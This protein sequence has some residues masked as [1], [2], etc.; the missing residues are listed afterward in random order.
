LGTFGQFAFVPGQPSAGSTSPLWSGLLALGYLLRVDYRVWAYALGAA[1]LSLNAWLVYRL[2]LNLW[3]ERARAALLAGAFAALEW[4]MAWAAA[5]G[6]ETLL[7]SALALAVFVIP[8]RRAGWLGVGVGLSV[9]ARPDGLTLLPFVLG[10]VLGGRGE[11]RRAAVKLVPACLLGFAAIFL[12]YLALN[13]ELG[14]AF[15]PNTFYAKAV[16]YAVLREQPLLARLWRVG[17]QPF[18]G[19]QALLAPGLVAAIWSGIKPKHWE[20]LLPLGWAW[21]FILAYVV[22]LPVTYQHGRYV[23]PVI[24][25]LLVMGSGGMS[26]LLQLNTSNFARR[27]FSRAWAAAIGLLAI[28][29]WII[30]AGAYARDV[31]IIETEMVATA[32]WVN[33]NTPPEALIA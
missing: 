16:E 28:A 30:G 12:P 21:A 6:M 13:R 20:T 26:T 8:P 4:H 33:Q 2:A 5:S 32:R 3:P 10:R 27:L 29:F 19:A 14:G 1:L 24:P 18:V 25:V 9:L 31:Q 7:F 11:G 22:R 15:W 17:L 23:I